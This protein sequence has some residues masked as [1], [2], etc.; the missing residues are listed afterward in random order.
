EDILD[1]K[2]YVT[3]LL[4]DGLNRVRKSILPE[5]VDSER[6]EMVPTYNRAGALEAIAFDGTDYVR[7]IAYNAKGQRVLLAMGNELMT[8]YAYDKKNYRLLR[9]KTEKY[10]EE[11]HEYEPQSGTTKQDSGYAYDL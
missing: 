5:D 10:E 8:R 11:D 4:Y 6:K 7:H 9:I 2:E 1:A 3:G